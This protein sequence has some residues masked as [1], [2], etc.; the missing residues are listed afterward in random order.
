[1]ASAVERRRREEQIGRALSQHFL[2]LVAEGRIAAKPWIREVQGRNV[3]FS[4]GT[5]EP[6]LPR[7][8]RIPPEND[9]PAA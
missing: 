5:E 6:K 2:P 9:P 7:R 3:R 4:D 1:M 8:G